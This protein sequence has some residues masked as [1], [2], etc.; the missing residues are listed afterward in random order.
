M[1]YHGYTIAPVT[2]RLPLGQHM[3]CV[4]IANEHRTT[5]AADVTLAKRAIDAWAAAKKVVTP[6]PSSDRKVRRGRRNPYA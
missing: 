6:V 1:T 5:Y 4:E 3:E 2:R